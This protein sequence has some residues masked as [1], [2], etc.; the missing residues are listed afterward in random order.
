MVLLIFWFMV[1]GRG[2]GGGSEGFYLRSD[3]VNYGNG[4]YLC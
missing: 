2:D 3:E 1:G 4:L